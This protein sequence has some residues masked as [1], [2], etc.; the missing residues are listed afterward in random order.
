MFLPPVRLDG[1]AAVRGEDGL[2]LLLC[3][4]RHAVSPVHLKVFVQLITVEH[5]PLAGLRKFL[6]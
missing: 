1:L 4:H 6:Q 5:P 3:S 2:I